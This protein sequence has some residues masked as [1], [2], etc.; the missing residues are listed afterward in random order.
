MQIFPSWCVMLQALLFTLGDPKCRLSVSLPRSWYGKG[1][2]R[3][4]GYLAPT[5]VLQE[6]V[7]RLYFPDPRDSSL[8]N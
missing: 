8:K 2:V 4:S 5:R 7:W 1:L 6:G 3:A